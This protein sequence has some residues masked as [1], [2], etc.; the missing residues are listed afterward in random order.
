MM[1]DG[2]TMLLHDVFGGIQ[3][4]KNV[5]NPSEVFIYKKLQITP[6]NDKCE[7]LGGKGNFLY[8]NRYYLTAGWI[9]SKIFCI[10]MENEYSFE[11]FVFETPLLFKSDDLVVDKEEK[12]AITACYET[13][14]YFAIVDIKKRE[15]VKTIPSGKGTCGLTMSCDQRYVFSSNDGENS[16]T[17]LD[18]KDWTTRKFSCDEGFKKLGIDGYIQGISMGM[19]NCVYVY[20]CSGN[21]AIVRF[22]PFDKNPTYE[23]SFP[24]SKII[25]IC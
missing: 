18:V 19:D 14:G 4:I 17:C 3:V 6:W 25:G 1:P 12:F 21:G 22:K 13:E 11:T 23:I 10:D 15:V 20:G 16:I 9:N 5:Q 8:N 7:T 24:G 2:N